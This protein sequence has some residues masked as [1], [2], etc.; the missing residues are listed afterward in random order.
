MEQARYPMG[1]EKDS[2]PFAKP[3]S[4]SNS[5]KFTASNAA[6]ACSGNGRRREKL[7]SVND[8]NAHQETAGIVEFVESLSISRK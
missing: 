1:A 3:S 8:E 6:T 5:S 7:P 4:I 2:P